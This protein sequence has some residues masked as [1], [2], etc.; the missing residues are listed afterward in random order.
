[1]IA[2]CIRSIAGLSLRASLVTSILAN[3]GAMVVTTAFFAAAF[4][5]MG[6]YAL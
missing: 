4:Y 6:R 3:L 5:L 1:L 2:F